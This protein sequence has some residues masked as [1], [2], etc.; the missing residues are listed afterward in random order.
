MRFS[1]AAMG[2]LLLAWGQAEPAAQRVVVV[3]LTGEVG[4]SMVA[5]VK[6]AARQIR[7]EKP[8]LVIFEI[9]TPGGRIDHM[10][11]IGEEIKRLDPIPTVAYVH[12]P[13]SGSLIM[14]GAISAGVYLAISCKRIYM[15]PGTVIGASAPVIMTGEGAKPVEEKGVSMARTKFRARAEENGY[16]VNLVVAMVDQDLEVFEVVV[17]GEKRYLTAR[18]IEKLKKENEDLE[19]PEVPFI[20]KGKLLTLTHTQVAETGMGKVAE[21]RGEILEEHGVSVPE[22]RLIE[23]S[24]SEALVGFVTSGVA[25]FILLIVGVL[26]IWVELKTPGFGVAGVVGGLSIALLLFGHH[27][28]G[29]AEMGEVLLILLG[30]ALVAV[31]IFLLPG[32]W[33]F[34]MAGGVCI[35]AGLILSMQSFVL[36]SPEKAPWEMETFLRSVGITLSAFAGGGVGL[37]ILLRFLPK[38]PVFNWLVLKEELEGAAPAPVQEEDITGRQGHAVTPL[39]PGGKIEIDG[40]IHDVVAEGDFVAKGEPVEVLRV[41]GMRIVVQ[42]MKR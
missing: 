10:I 41:E 42:K 37:M 39:H 7:A 24:W 17:E 34:G 5:L 35:L 40:E 12:P 28:A 30:I 11:M 29:M 15:A 33:L 31:E 13:E 9:D 19:V 20:A 18:E 36:P 27:L 2:V 21:S 14:G 4:Y 22:V 25:S 38:V 6:R 8:D 23:E 32:T 1:A 3:P 26:G 16:P